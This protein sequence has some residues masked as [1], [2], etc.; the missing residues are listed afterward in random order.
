MLASRASTY[1]SRSGSHG[2][3]IPRRVTSIDS[4]IASRY[5]LMLAI[6]SAKSACHSLRLRASNPRI[7]DAQ[8]GSS[9]QQVTPPL[10]SFSVSGKTLTSPPGALP[11]L[12]VQLKP[13][14]KLQWRDALRRRGDRELRRRSL[15]PP[16]WKWPRCTMWR[17]GSS[18]IM[19]AQK[20]RKAPTLLLM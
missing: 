8:P 19:Y 1:R 15:F 16:Y 13:A 7:P 3:W 11:C 2:R 18:N 5:R 17:L 12:S 6:A 4:L 9:S 10:T 20:K 14:P